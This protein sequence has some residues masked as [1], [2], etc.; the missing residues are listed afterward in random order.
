MRVEWPRIKLAVSDGSG[1]VADALEIHFGVAFVRVDDVDAAPI[2][3]LH[4]D[5]PEAVLVIAGD[6]QTAAHGGEFS[7]KLERPLVAGDLDD[8]IAP[9]ISRESSHLTEDAAVIVHLDCG[10]R[11][12]FL[13]HSQS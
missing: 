13:R 2:P 7:G 1:G 6:N 8:S 5:V 4:V 3:E 10:R 9:I 12:E 11:A